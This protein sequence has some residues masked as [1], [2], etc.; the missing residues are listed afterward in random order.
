MKKNGD[1]KNVTAVDLDRLAAR[2]E[3]SSVAEYV[4]LSQKTGRI[5]WLNF[6]SGVARGL[7]FTVGTAIVVALAYKVI[8]HIIS[9][10][11]PY[12]TEILSEFVKMIN[13]G[14]VP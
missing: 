4:R 1:Q 7:G 11:I 8:S 5:L 10:N 6:I 9:M 3:N 14:G 2:L 12:I 13:S